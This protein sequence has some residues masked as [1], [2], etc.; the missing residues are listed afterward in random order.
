MHIGKIMQFRMVQMIVARM[1]VQHAERQFQREIMPIAVHV[2]G[3]MIATAAKVNAVQT[4][5][6]L[7]TGTAAGIAQARLC[8]AAATTTTRV[9]DDTK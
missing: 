4:G 9:R 5:I 3:N 1:T 7:R 2:L 6:E 8:L